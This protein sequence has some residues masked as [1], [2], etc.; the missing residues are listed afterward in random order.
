MALFALLG[1]LRGFSVHLTCRSKGVIELCLTVIYIHF[2]LILQKQLTT[3]SLMSVLP[4]LSEKRLN[5][6]VIS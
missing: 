3:V 5:R 1:V 4:Q 6:G 2:L